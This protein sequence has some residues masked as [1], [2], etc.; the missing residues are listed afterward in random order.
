MH[1]TV[2]TQSERA[3]LFFDQGLK[4]TYAFNHEAAIQSYR[5]A[6][7]L[8]PN[9]AMAYWGIAYA[10]GPNINSAMS[11]EGKRKAYAAIEQA[12]L[13][14]SDAT[15]HERDYIDAPR[16]RYSPYSDADRSLLDVAYK[17]A[18]VGVS[19]RYPDDVD[20]LVLYA[21]GR[22]ELH[23][24]KWWRPD[25]TPEEGTLALKDLASTNTGLQQQLRATVPLEGSDA[26]ETASGLAHHQPAISYTE[27]NIDGRRRAGG[28]DGG[29]IAIEPF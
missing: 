5:S 19:V 9:L 10:L 23:L 26:V 12:V 28:V 29:A 8:D 7:E 4:L 14:E 20:A 25:G 24:W 22:M 27:P 13:L 21:E 6:Q 17:D 1:H 18:M 15:Q 3:Q 16:K 11:V 2:S